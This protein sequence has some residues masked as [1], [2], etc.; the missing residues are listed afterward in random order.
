MDDANKIDL[1]ESIQKIYQI[2]HKNIK[3]FL[4]VLL[5][6]VLLTM[7]SG[8]IQYRPQYSSQITFTVTKEIN[9]YTY[10][11]YNTEAVEKITNSFN[12][13]LSSQPLRDKMEAELDMAYIPASLSLSR[14]P[15]TNMFTVKAT[16]SNP[17]D[18]YK[19]ILAFNENY[20]TI[21]YIY[22]KEECYE[23]G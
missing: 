13:L 21:N 18:A 14:I 4:I 12:Y 7:V 1:L 5:S 3:M 2:L 23:P 8:Y 17:E 19:V 22:E 15:S 20:A 11:R 6:S 16:S 9:G 10:F